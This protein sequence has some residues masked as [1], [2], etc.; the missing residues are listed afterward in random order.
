[1]EGRARTRYWNRLADTVNGI[2]HCNYTGTQCASR[3]TRLV[4]LYHVSKIKLYI[5]IYISILVLN[6]WYSIFRIR[7]FTNPTIRE[8]TRVV[9]GSN[10]S[11]SCTIDFGSAQLIDTI[12]GEIR[13][14]LQHEIETG[15]VRDLFSEM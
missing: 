1:M 12:V 8:A 2:A 14:K 7:F 11:I 9:Q 5:Y 4:H 3:F 6:F 13:I 10:F 15:A